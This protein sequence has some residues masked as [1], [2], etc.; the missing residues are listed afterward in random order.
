MTSSRF[1]VAAALWAGLASGAAAQAG[2]PAPI[3]TRWPGGSFSVITENDKWAFRG[4]DRHYTNG[5]RFSWVSDI[6]NPAEPS[7]GSFAYRLGQLLPTFNPSGEFRYGFSIGHNMYTPGDVRRTTAIPDDR[8]YAGWLYGGL[9]LIQ[10]TRRAPAGVDT[11][12][13]LE[14]NLDPS[15]GTHF[16]AEARHG[17]AGELVPAW[18]RELLER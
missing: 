11:L 12:D 10:E 8:P 3:P 7:F 4:E 1:L 5:V 2:D 17:R 13:T 9:A 15:E 18:V 14:I 6:V 16:F